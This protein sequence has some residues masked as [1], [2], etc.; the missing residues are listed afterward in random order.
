MA[1]LSI[2][3]NKMHMKAFTTIP[4]VDEQQIETLESC[5]LRDDDSGY[6]NFIKAWW[7]FFLHFAGSI[8]LFVSLLSWIHD[9]KFN[10]G[11]HLSIVRIGDCL[12][13]TQVNG[14]IS[15][16]LVL[17][18]LLGSCCTTILV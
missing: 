2:D 3:A 12:F 15:L 7:Y 11:S 4:V 18:R 9:H 10:T 5:A 1:S 16:A 17:I 13:Q 8:L 14:L 6:R